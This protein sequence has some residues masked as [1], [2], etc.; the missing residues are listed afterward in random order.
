M[1]DEAEAAAMVGMAL[2]AGVN[3]V[4][5]A[6]VYGQGNKERW[7]GRALG[8]RRHEVILT[9]K[10]YGR[11]GDG[12][13]DAGL[14]RQHIVAACEASLHR[15]GTDYVDLYLMHGF[16]STIPMEESLRAFDDLV[17]A[18]K[19]RYVG[20]SNWAAWELVKALG[21]AEQHG[22]TRFVA[23]Q[24]YYS[25]LSRDLELDLIPACLDAG[26]GLMVWSPLSGGFLSGKYR[27]GA[28]M[29]D[30]KAANAETRAFYGIDEER[31]YDV[32]DTLDE[33]G[34]RR[35]ASVAQVALGYLLRKPGVTSVVVGARTREQL[36]DNLGAAH[37]ALSDEEI[38]RLDA[39]T[40]PP[41]IYPHWLRRPS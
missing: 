10:V 17:R 26:V 18:G 16:D 41:R 27:R 24:A 12:P 14:S 11:V 1:R 7:L 3:F 23:L 28:P 34:R 20:C 9:T 30:G 32:I 6:D 25:L 5:T 22:W 13:N 35:G 37:V 8:S 29:P 40:P 4:D 2:D 15:L 31:A 33:I 39:L 19:V 21:I 36:A 38:A